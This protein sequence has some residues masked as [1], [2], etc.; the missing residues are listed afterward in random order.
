MQK[1]LPKKFKPYNIWIFGL[2]LWISSIST[3]GKK[4]YF[5][6]SWFALERQ[7]GQ[8][9]VLRPLSCLNF[10]YL[11][12]PKMCPSVSWVNNLYSLFTTNMLWN[13]RMVRHQLPVRLASMLLV[14]VGS[15]LGVDEWMSHPPT[16]PNC[17]AASPPATTLNPA[18]PPTACHGF[19][20]ENIKWKSD[21]FI[22]R[23]NTPSHRNDCWKQV[24]LNGVS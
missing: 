3:S 17:T 19:F 10:V 16:S 22:K 12:S 15:K 5:A 18:E 21:V 6:F 23:G 13:V 1:K 14:T 8:S 4:R 9:N 20:Y 2:S 24:L 7:T 11:A